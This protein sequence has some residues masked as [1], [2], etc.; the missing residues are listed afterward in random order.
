MAGEELTALERRVRELESEL[1][2]ARRA[3]TAL[4]EKLAEGDGRPA[5][6][7]PAATVDQPA[8]PGETE[9]ELRRRNAELDRLNRSKSE[10]ISIAA[11]EFRTPMTSIVGYL[12]LISQGRLGPIPDPMQ[13]PVASLMRNTQRLKRLIDD[14]LDVSRLD[15]GRMVLHRDARDLR[16][17]ARSA[18]GELEAFTLA[19]QHEVET[20]FAEVPLVD[21]DGDKIHQVITNLLANAI[22][23]TPE[24]GRILV[25]VGCDGEWAVLKVRD[26]GIGIPE[27]ARGKIFE[28]FS[29]I[30]APQ[31]HSSAGPDSAGLGLYIARGIVLLHGGAIAVDSREAQYTEF[32]VRLP[33]LPGARTHGGTTAAA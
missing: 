30:T 14:M 19:K 2:A 28:P 26:N 8:A 15:S 12:D 24:G 7:V 16:E 20:E 5:V 23:Y 13:R 1:G 18:I 21:V 11:H 32:T 3:I 9:S 33:L 22:K 6:T 17:L 4:T 29:E 10:F 31:F 27:G 25:S